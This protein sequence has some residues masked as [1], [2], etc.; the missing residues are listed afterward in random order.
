MA[1]RSLPRDHHKKLCLQISQDMVGRRRLGFA[2]Q[3]LPPVIGIGPSQVAPGSLLQDVGQ[4]ERLQCG[5]IVGSKHWS[6]QRSR[7]NEG[8]GK[9]HS[10]GLMVMKNDGKPYWWTALMR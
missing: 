5:Q 4:M 2:E 10:Y 7:T 3:L 1:A 6:W 9:V 8:Q